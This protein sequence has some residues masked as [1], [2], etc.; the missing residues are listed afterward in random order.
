MSF[1]KRPKLCYRSHKGL[2]ALSFLLFLFVSKT[3]LVADL[4]NVIRCCVTRNLIRELP[5]AIVGKK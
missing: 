5:F 1:L 2:P 4:A 3:K